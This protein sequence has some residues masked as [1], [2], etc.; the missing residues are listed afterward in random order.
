MCG[1]YGVTH[2]SLIIILC[3]LKA[4]C[5]NIR[6]VAQLLCLNVDRNYVLGIWSSYGL[7]GPGIESQ[8]WRS[9][10]LS[11]RPALRTNQYPIQWV[12]VFFRGGGG[13]DYRGVAFS[14]QS[15]I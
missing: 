6:H 1:Y 13:V 4:L 5:H 8:C 10:L 2:G 9:F 7:N 14:I 3:L 15:N 12:L 11:S